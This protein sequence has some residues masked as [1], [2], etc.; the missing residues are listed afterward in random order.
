M[1][2]LRRCAVSCLFVSMGAMAS[3]DPG[4]SYDRYDVCGYGKVISLGLTTDS[5]N[6]D[7]VAVIVE[8]MP[9]SGKYGTF[10]GRDVI[11]MKRGNGD[12]PS[13]QIF[14]FKISALAQALVSGLPVRILHPPN[15][16]VSAK[17]NASIDQFDIR[18]CSTGSPCWRPDKDL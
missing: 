18:V 11:G 3:A 13:R 2:R 10:R 12:S 4:L 1:N 17:C 15:D 5:E 14:S 16:G 8:E 9:N 7:W 6:R